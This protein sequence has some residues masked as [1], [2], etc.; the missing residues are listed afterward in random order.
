MAISGYHEPSVV[1]NLGMKVQAASHNGVVGHV[2]KNQE[3]IAISLAG[4]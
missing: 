4:I 2:L 3:A 1:F